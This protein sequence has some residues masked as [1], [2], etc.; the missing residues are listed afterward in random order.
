MA[1]APVAPVPITQDQTATYLSGFNH[2]YDVA[3]LYRNSGAPDAN[4]LHYT[5]RDLYHRF[6]ENQMQI[7]GGANNMFAA[8]ADSGGLT[9]GY[10]IPKPKDFS[11][12]HKNQRCSLLEMKS[13]QPG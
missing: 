5:N 1:G 9:M 7:N 13:R 3:A 10:F 8:W 11:Y 2:P 4:P 12:P 6:Y